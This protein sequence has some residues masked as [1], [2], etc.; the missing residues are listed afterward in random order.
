VGWKWL[1]YLFSF[2]GEKM[3]GHIFKFGGADGA[4]E[5]LNEEKVLGTCSAW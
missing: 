3:V 4:S 2:V 1:K 5:N